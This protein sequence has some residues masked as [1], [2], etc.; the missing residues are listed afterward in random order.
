MTENT[1]AVQGQ[2]T[3]TILTVNRESVHMSITYI[4]IF[5]FCFCFGEKVP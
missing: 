1:S 2:W 4:Y 5:F 3:E